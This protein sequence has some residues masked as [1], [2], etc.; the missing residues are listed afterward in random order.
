M[1][2]PSFATEKSRLQDACQ[3]LRSFTLARRGVTKQDGLKGIKRVNSLRD[4]L[5]RLFGTGTDARQV[6]LLVASART[7]VAAA[8]ARLALLAKNYSWLT[9]TATS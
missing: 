1:P 4:R 5:L 8:Q 3:I 7:Q 2:K 6:A 9:G